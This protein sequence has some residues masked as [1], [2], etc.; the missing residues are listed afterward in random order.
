MYLSWF[1]VEPHLMP[2]VCPIQRESGA[3]LTA[4]WPLELLH[5]TL[6]GMKEAGDWIAERRRHSLTLWWR[7]LDP[8]TRA[9]LKLRY[10][11]GP[12]FASRPSIDG[13]EQVRM[14]NQNGHWQL[15]ILGIV[16]CHS[17]RFI[18]SLGTSVWTVA[19][20]PER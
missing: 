3:K 14:P 6:F 16:H 15:L 2:H 20:S 13:A 18:Q 19:A 7:C 11:T 10:A 17:S 8:L 1:E 4:Q 5:L 12:L 9:Y